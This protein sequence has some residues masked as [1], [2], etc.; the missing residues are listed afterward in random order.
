MGPPAKR[1]RVVESEAAEDEQ[2]LGPKPKSAP[3]PQPDSE[4]EEDDDDDEDS[5][6]DDLDDESTF[7]IS[8]EISL[9]DHTKVRIAPS[10]G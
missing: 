1:A 10:L 9:K 4:V 6:A 3:E 8:H 2:D 5:G 7:P